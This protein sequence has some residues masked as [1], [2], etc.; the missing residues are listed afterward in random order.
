MTLHVFLAA[1]YLDQ[2]TGPL[3]YLASVPIPLPRTTP[4]FSLGKPGVPILT[5]QSHYYGNLTSVPTSPSS[6]TS[7][8]FTKKGSQK[9]RSPRL[10]SRVFPN[11]LT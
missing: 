2:P 11:I 9:F 10:T 6:Q 4:D 3:A 1:C 8:L 7:E 5:L